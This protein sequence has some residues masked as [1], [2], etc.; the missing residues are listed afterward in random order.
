MVP[1]LM[2]SILRN[3]YGQD[4]IFLKQYIE[5]WTQNK[6]PAISGGP[7]LQLVHVES[8]MTWSDSGTVQTFAL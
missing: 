8:V 6:I 3:V 4:H 1:F 2:K 7:R 5:V